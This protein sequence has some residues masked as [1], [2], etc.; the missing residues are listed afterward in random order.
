MCMIYSL[1]CTDILQIPT[2][3]F[4]KYVTLIHDIKDLIHQGWHI[5]IAQ[6]LK[7]GNSF[8]D[9]LTKPRASSSIDLLVHHS[10]STDI[11][12]LLSADSI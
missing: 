7:E 3:R 12:D 11:M 9:F 2:L 5:R 1:H 10:P 8:A 4:H 6:T